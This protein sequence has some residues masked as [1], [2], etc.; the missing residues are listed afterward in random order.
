MSIRR[1]LRQAI[2][3]RFADIEATW[4]RVGTLTTPHV[5]PVADS[6]VDSPA[7]HSTYHFYSFCQN[8]LECVA[9]AR[10]SL[11][12]IVV[13]AKYLLASSQRHTIP[14][15]SGSSRWSRWLLSCPS[16]SL[17]VRVQ[18]DGTESS[19]WDRKRS[20]PFSE[21][22]PNRECCSSCSTWPMGI[23]VPARSRRHQIN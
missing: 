1:S 5:T 18:N 23:Q 2:L 15:Y 16:P 8:V 10:L 4:N 7:L 17:P 9:D 11:R 22:S 12:L 6:A 14:R 13:R 21:T 19:C 20:W 3:R